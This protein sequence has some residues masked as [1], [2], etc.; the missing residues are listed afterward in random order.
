[1]IE[2]NFDPI[3]ERDEKAHKI[4]AYSFMLMFLEFAFQYCL[5]NSSNFDLSILINIDAGIVIVSLIL[6]AFTNNYWFGVNIVIIMIEE[7]SEIIPI[8]LDLS[9]KGAFKIDK[10]FMTILFLK[11]VLDSFTIYFGFYAYKVFKILYQEQHS[12]FTLS[13]FMSIIIPIREANSVE[14]SNRRISSV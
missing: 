11:I 14:F 3:I 4:I 6:L 13:T 5:Q 7:L 2:I 1:M 12:V 8:A 10:L 9:W